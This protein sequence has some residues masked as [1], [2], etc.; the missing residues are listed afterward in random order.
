M[1]LLHNITSLCYHQL[2]RH[3]ELQGRT[4]CTFVSHCVHQHQKQIDKPCHILQIKT[5]V[6]K[7]FYSTIWQE[8]LRRSQEAASPS[9]VISL[10]VCC[11]GLGTS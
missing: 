5:V 8:F 9:Y 1:P 11:K 6:S 2:E 10:P 7:L 3:L 4:E